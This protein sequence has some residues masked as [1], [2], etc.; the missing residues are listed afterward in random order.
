[1]PSLVR[2]RLSFKQPA[3]SDRLRVKQPVPS[4]HV[5][6]AITAGAAVAAGRRSQ[7]S[8]AVADGDSKLEPMLDVS[9]LLSLPTAAPVEPMLEVS[10][11]SSLSTAAPVGGPTLEVSELFG[12]VLA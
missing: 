7:K 4:W 6:S 11:L 8:T 1:M 10:N 5:P 3:L 12:F 2:R 9:K